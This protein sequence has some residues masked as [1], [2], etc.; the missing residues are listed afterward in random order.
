M[1]RAVID[2]SV[3][4]SWFLP[5]EVNGK[6]EDILNNIDKI[7]IYVPSI[8][9]YELMNILLNAEKRKRIDHPTAL[10]VLD[11]VGHYP[12]N[13]ES[14]TSLRGENIKIFEMSQAYD[15]TSY[16]TAYL[17]LALRLNV[18]L[19]TYDKSLFNT[20]KKLRLRTAL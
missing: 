11:I 2:A 10:K 8:F 20:A 5:D 6:Y 9:E 4:I 3:V 7:S 16:D 12:I 15:L 18:P 13:V 1:P 19:I 14:S 17:E